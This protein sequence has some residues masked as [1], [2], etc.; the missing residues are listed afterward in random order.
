[1]QL[2]QSLVH[3]VLHSFLQDTRENVKISNEPGS[4]EVHGPVNDSGSPAKF[5]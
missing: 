3:P 2:F 4:S 1:M 5:T